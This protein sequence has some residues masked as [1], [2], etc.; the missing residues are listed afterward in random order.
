MFF[1]LLK[2]SDELSNEVC[3]NPTKKNC[4]ELEVV[5]ELAMQELKEIMKQRKNS[6]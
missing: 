2:R 4:K 6:A 5:T 3:N 1:E